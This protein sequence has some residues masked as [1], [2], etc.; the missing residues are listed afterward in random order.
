MNFY[1]LYYLLNKNTN[2]GYIGYTNDPNRRLYDHVKSL[3]E[4]TH[5]NRCLSADYKQDCLEVKILEVYLNKDNAFICKREKELIEQYDTFRNGYNQTIGGEAQSNTRAFSQENIFQAYALLSFYPEM[6]SKI[7][8]DIF[9]MSESAVLRLR[10]KEAHISIIAIFERLSEDR[11][12]SLKQ[13]LDNKYGMAHRLEAHSVNVVHKARILNRDTT[14]M[15]IAVG[16]NREKM[17]AHMERCLS[18][19]SSHCSRIIRGLRYKEFYEEYFNMSA[20]DQ[21]LWLK[22]GLDFFNIN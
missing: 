9:S 12:D 15:I 3:E 2:K 20:D 5:P 8:Q 21:I 4:G 14:L 17:G 7:V 18:L 10:R 22:K 16:N 13:E 19:P 11:K 1:Y 6:S